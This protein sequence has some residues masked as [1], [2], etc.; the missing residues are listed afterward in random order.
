[1]GEIIRFP[2]KMA[3]NGAQ[4]KPAEGKTPTDHTAKVLIFTGS[5]YSRVNKHSRQRQKSP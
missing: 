1:M 2:E 4:A 5:R 3:A